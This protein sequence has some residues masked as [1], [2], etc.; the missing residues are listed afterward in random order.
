MVTVTGVAL[1]PPVVV[2]RPS[3]P[4]WAAK[5]VGSSVESGLPPDDELE[6]LLEDEELEEDE[7]DEDALEEDELDEEELEEPLSL[8]GGLVSLE[9]PP[10]QA[11]SRRVTA[12]V[13]GK[14][15]NFIVDA[16]QLE[17]MTLAGWR[18][19]RSLRR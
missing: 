1:P 2:S 9:P 11:E 6:L 19:S 10:P 16:L 15:Q 17:K 12:R 14:V 8:S 3:L 5:P 4:D 7:L 13:T 18:Q